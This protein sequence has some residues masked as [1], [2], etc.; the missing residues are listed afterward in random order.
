MEL[1][2]PSCGQALWAPD[3]DAPLAP[4]PQADDASAKKGGPDPCPTCGTSMPYHPPQGAEGEAGTVGRWLPGEPAPSPSDEADKAFPS[5]LAEP[6]PEPGYPEQV[7]TRARF[8]ADIQSQHARILEGRPQPELLTA[9][10]A[11]LAGRPVSHR[12]PLGSGDDAGPEPT[13]AD[14][15]AD[16]THFPPPKLGTPDDEHKKDEGDRKD[17]RS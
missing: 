3:G 7:E 4:M 16:A 13:M 9:E 1:K 10:P 12:D 5:R 6:M 15:A 2:C 17:R 14:A 8:T 11:H